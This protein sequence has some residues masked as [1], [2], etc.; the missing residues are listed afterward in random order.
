MAQHLE[1]CNKIDFLLTQEFHKQLK[2]QSSTSGG[3]QPKNNTGSSLRSGNRRAVDPLHPPVKDVLEF[4]QELYERG[5]R[6]SCLNTARSALSSIIVLDGNVTVGNHPLVQRFLKGVFQTRPA[7]PR[8]T[9]T[10][11]T[12]IVLTDLKTLHPPKEISLQT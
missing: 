5:L 12:S 4:L 10:W 1:C 6:Y 7:F 9:T 3:Q 8:Y 2:T 11:D